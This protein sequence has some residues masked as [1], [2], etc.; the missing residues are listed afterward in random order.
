MRNLR[1][2]FSG[3]DVSSLVAKLQRMPWLWNTNTA[4]TEAEDS[5]HHGLDDIWVRYAADFS[6]H[7][8]PFEAVWY[9]VI[10][11]LPE[12][13]QICSAIM[14]AVGGDQLGG[15]LITRI[16]PGKICKPHEDKGWHADF[17]DKYAVQIQG[18]G[19]QAFCFEEG[20]YSAMPGE[21]YWF[22]N[23]AKHWVV[24]DSD[25]DRI[26]M[27]VCIRHAQFKEN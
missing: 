12:V 17:Y 2:M 8:E 23:H 27:I 21:V 4:R 14:Y 6:K 15:V 20:R 13:R 16:P 22:E 19:K 5:P 11:Q 24:N 18:N 9:P 10:Q 26:T 3:V 25:E 7:N 1:P